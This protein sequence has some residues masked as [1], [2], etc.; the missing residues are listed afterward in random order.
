MKLEAITIRR[1][2]QAD[3]I[4]AIMLVM[5]TANHLRRKRGMP[6]SRIKK[7]KQP[8]G[9]LV[10]FLKTDPEG[11]FVAHDRKGK[12][13]G[14]TMAMIRED[15]WYLAFLF[16]DPTLQSKGIGQKL[17]DKAMRYGKK[18]NCKRW[19]LCTFAFNPQAIAVYTKMGMPPQRP[20]LT[21]ERKRKDDEAFK[22][23]RAPIKLTVTKITE[24]KYINR[25]TALDRRARQLARPEEHFF[26]LADENY[27]TLIF[28]D[29]KKL[30]GYAVVNSRGMVAPVVASD[31]KYLV[32][33]MAYAVEWGAAQ[34]HKFQILF[35]QGEQLEVLRMLMKAGFHIDE[36][37]LV[38]ASEQVSD[39]KLYIPATLAHF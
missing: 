12:L 28:H 31:P 16:V 34:G 8:P 17:L 7:L 2:R 32:S 15:E 23:L 10:H 29:G 22:K 6:V 24:E 37:T 35:V 3:L 21:M 36:T 13:V 25:L 4:D 26:W 5:T 33:L 30:V 18:N 38:M 1:T 9:L 19:A 39:P 27:N 20:L 11:S 14:F